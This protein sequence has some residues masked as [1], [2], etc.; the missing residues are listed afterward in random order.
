[1]E[2]KAFSYILSKNGLKIFITVLFRK[3]VLGYE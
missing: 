2:I 3:Y 1:M